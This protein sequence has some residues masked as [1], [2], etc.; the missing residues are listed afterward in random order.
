MTSLSRSVSIARAAGVPWTRSE[1]PITSAMRRR[2]TPGDSRESP[3]ATT[4]TAWSRSEGSESLTMKPLA[5]TRSAS[6]T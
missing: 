6:K 3:R 2:V 5:P 1:R 4:R